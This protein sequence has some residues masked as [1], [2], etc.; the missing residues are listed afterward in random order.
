MTVTLL[1]VCGVLAASFLWI[2][3][4][5]SN[6]SV[7]ALADSSQRLARM[8]DTIAGVGAAQ[9]SYVA[10]GQLDEPWFERT[11]AHLDQLAIDI[12]QAP[13]GLRSP[14]AADAMQALADSA[15][16]LVAAD[17]RARQNLGIGQDMMASDVIFSD[18]HN[19]IDTMTAS[20]RDLQA[21]EQQTHEARLASLTGQRW[22]A[23][24]AL[25][26][27]WTL[28]LLALARRPAATL[29]EPTLAEPT[30]AEPT[31]AEPVVPIETAEAHDVL[32]AEDAALD[33]TLVAA[34]CTDLSRVTSPSALPDLLGRAARIL[35]ASGLIL[36]ISAG[37]QLF[38][39]MGHGYT[40][41][42]LARLA[43]L[44]RQG[45][46]AAAAAWRTGQLTVVQSTG[47]S[48]NG[49]IVA[50]LLGLDEC[51]GVLAAE[52]GHGVADRP[53]TRA[54]ATV[55][56]AQLA[57]VVP[58]WPAA[59]LTEPGTAVFAE[60]PAEAGAT[61]DAEAPASADA[62]ALNVRSA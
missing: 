54:L 28:G 39:V 2:L 55:I 6:E 8:S 32:A 30:L 16:A 41:A 53:A 37:E 9:R 46:N 23:L 51:V 56:A 24:A 10:P 33:L 15:D 5:R 14:G 20:L 3:E 31:L 22:A 4:Q 62:S 50:P 45:D 27:V 36:W 18:G 35:D 11:S 47:P 13:A 52:V 60:A 40:P 48:D 34:L 58:A 21:A 12:G 17:A 19:I 25:A 44:A 7:T 61:P 49:A 26:V 59:S 1:V 38:P 42:V 29:A 43:P 57:T